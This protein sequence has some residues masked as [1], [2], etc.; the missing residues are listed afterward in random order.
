MTRIIFCIL[1]SIFS[2]K[3]SASSYDSYYLVPINSTSIKKINN[4][5]A[6]YELFPLASINAG[7]LD[8]W[9][10]NQVYVNNDFSQIVTFKHDVK[11][12]IELNKW[13]E[14][15]SGRVYHYQNDG[16]INAVFVKGMS[17][18]NAKEI[19]E[20]IKSVNVTKANFHFSLIESAV[21]SDCKTLNTAFAFPQIEK[22]SESIMFQ[23]ILSCSTG[24]QTGAYESTI[25]TVEQVGDLAWSGLKALGHEAKELYT[26]PNQK[27][28][29][30]YN[31]VVK[32]A[33][34]LKD[35]MVFAVNMAINPNQA[36]IKLK[37]VYGKSADKIIDIFNNLKNLPTPMMVEMSCSIISGIGVDALIA[38]LTFGAGSAKLALTFE[39]ITRQTATLGKV[40]DALGKVS[41]VGKK[42]VQ[43]SK[44][45][46]QKFIR[47]VSKNEVPEGDL[48][49][50]KGFMGET[51]AD[52][53]TGLEA[54]AC[55]I[56]K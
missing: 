12:N 19:V 37:Q 3:V 50:I 53:K 7:G 41:V 20:K 10:V 18:K 6:A 44:E 2:L 38:Y 34:V 14:L 15:S 28:D 40:F 23:S 21:A 36:A 32:G 56:Q 4:V 1:F 16:K 33:F 5:I 13:E 27:L 11:G 30:Y 25:G 49:A 26:N 42:G 9:G 52:N 45:H 22:I 43:L 31:G 47:K 39:R 54:F 17:E 48:D 29:Q 51:A 35:I 8:L 46:M 55:Y 24:A